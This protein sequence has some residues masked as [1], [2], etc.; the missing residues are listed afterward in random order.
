VL[1][2]AQFLREKL[3]RSD[4]AIGQSYTMHLQNLFPLCPRSFSYYSFFGSIFF[5]TDAI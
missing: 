5:N 4:W 2:S 1:V 3:Q